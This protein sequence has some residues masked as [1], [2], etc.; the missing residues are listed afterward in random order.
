MPAPEVDA[1][2]LRLVYFR[3]P[4]WLTERSNIGG[5]PRHPMGNLRSLR[6]LQKRAP[7]WT[8]QFIYTD[9]KDLTAN[10]RPALWRFNNRLGLPVWVASAK[11]RTSKAA[12]RLAPRPGPAWSAPE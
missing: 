1:N 12:D 9:A 6:L 5:D 8:K 4:V 11:S 10:R 2:D 7:V 3:S